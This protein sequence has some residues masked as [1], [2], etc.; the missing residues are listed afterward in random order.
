MSAAPVQ[1]VDRDVDEEERLE[2][3]AHLSREQSKRIRQR[4]VRLLGSLLRPH[5]WLIALMLGGIVIA[6]AFAVVG[7][8]VLAYV[9]DTALPAILR[10]DPRPAAFSVGAYA[11]AGVGE[12]LLTLGVIRL[13]ARISQAALLDLRRRIFL[14]AQRLSLEFH[15]RY[16]SG[17]MISRQ[18]NDVDS[19]DMFLS[20]ALGDL[21]SSFFYMALIT[22]ALT[23]LDPISMLVL[24]VALVP[25]AFLFRWFQRRASVLYRESSTRSARLIVKFVE[26]MTGIRAVQAF[27]AEER[28]DAHYQRLSDEFRDTNLRMMR[29]FGVFRTSII[30]AAN[31]SI[32]VLVLVDGLRV[33][34]GTLGVGVLVAAVLYSRQFF[35]PIEEMGDFFNSFQ[36]A[37]AALLRAG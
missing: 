14:Q 8:R 5:R 33:A 22:I 9:L 12:G 35:Q 25:L 2:D 4:S 28:N 23:S 29:T 17:R 6:Q 16:T 11:L 15:E 24:V 34:S 30:A 19:I 3:R 32:A 13:N 37:S 31:T 1:D 27:R 10:G 26:T 20:G 7:P 36:S 21:L 18:T